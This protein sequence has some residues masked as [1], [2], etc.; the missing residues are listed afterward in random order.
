MT[1][2]PGTPPAW[3][4]AAAATLAG[5]A[6]LGWRSGSSPSARLVVAASFATAIV[7]SGRIALAS[8]RPPIAPDAIEPLPGAGA[9]FTVIVAARD[10][11]N[12]LPRL[13]ADLGTQDHRTDEGRPLFEL[14]VVDD[15]ST[16]GTPQAALRAAAAAGLGDVTRLVRRSGDGLPDGK[17]A[18]LTAVATES[19]H[20]DFI[21]VLDAD[22]RVGAGFL[23]TLARYA[24]AGADA[25]TVR[26]RVLHPDRS[27]LAGAQADEQTADGEI[28]RGRWALGGCS[29]FRGNGIVVRRELLGAVGGWRAEALTEDLDLSS[30]IA[31]ARGVTV[32]WAIDAEVWEEPVLTWRALWRQRTRWAEG[33]LRRAIEHAPAVLGSERLALPAKL[34]FATYVGQ[35]AAPPVLLGALTRAA[36]TWRWKGAAALVAAYA[37]VAGGLGF[38]ALRWEHDAAGRPLAVSERLWRAGR[39]A[40]F[41]GVWIAAVPA[42]MWRLA[43]RRGAVAYDKMPHE[44]AG[45]PAPAPWQA[46]RGPSLAGVAVRPAATHAGDGAE[47]A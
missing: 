17:G 14:I 28:Q 3:R 23:A 5:G 20:G 19:C 24:A 42:A 46:H 44:G 34:D 36:V 2:A 4:V 15:R 31:A 27:H 7:A 45:E 21:V 11:A 32:A 9:T 10:E 26:R 25:M 18:A 41:G 22:A 12:A 47:P 13:I 38:D 43:S 33:A 1:D 16:D 40:A 35:I 30:R 29:E 39:L 37:I 6:V 8:R